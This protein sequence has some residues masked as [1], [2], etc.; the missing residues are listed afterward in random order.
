MSDQPNLYT[1]AEASQLTGFSTEALR[2]RIKRGKLAAE[3]GNDGHPRVRL[4]SADLEDFR[5]QLDQQKPTLTRQD[6]DRTNVIKALEAAVDSLRE[7]SGR[8]RAALTAEAATLRDALNRERERTDRLETDRSAAR[9]LADRRGQEVVELRERV[10]QAE[11]ESGAMRE[12]VKAER[13]RAGRAEAER[14][15][16]KVAAA[17]AESE[18]KGLREALAEAR[19]PFWRRWLGP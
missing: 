5:R 18:A 2:L 7:Q 1:L 13:E 9:A 12:Q 3:R 8:E 11:G 16:A 14:E 4:T 19:R 15:A 6:A 10:G 17:A